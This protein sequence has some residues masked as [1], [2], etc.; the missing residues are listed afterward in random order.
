LIDRVR[1]LDVS[2]PRDAFDARVR[3]LVAEGELSSKL[4]KDLLRVHNSVL[5]GGRT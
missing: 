3:V 4:A 2:P 5:K 1:A